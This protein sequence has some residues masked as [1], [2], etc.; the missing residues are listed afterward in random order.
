MYNKYVI[1]VLKFLSL[2]TAPESL[3]LPPHQIFLQ[4][5][6]NVVDPMAL[7]HEKNHSPPT[8]SMAFRLSMIY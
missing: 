7:I 6:N 3:P 5:Y 8:F 4:T 2:Y 1:L